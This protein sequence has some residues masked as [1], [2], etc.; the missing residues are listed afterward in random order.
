MPDDAIL[1]NTNRTPT[2]TYRPDDYRWQDGAY[3]MPPDYWTRVRPSVYVVPYPGGYMDT[4]L[5]P[6]TVPVTALPARRGGATP[7]TPPHARR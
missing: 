3:A 2:T 7:R 1:L 4:H 5:P 6:A